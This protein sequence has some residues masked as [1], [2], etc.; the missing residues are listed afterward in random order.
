MTMK[1]FFGEK[2]TTKQFIET[3]LAEPYRSQA[4]A[5]MEKLPLWKDGEP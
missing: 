2:K 1:E 5:N 3:E 4:L